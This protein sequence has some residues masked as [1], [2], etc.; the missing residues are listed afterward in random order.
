M[1]RWLLTLLLLSMVGLCSRPA[2]AVPP[3]LAT[4]RAEWTWSPTP[5]HYGVDPADVR[6]S[7]PF[8]PRGTPRV[9]GKVV[10]EPGRAVVVWMSALSTV[11]VRKT[12]PE[13][14][15]TLS[16]SRVEPSAGLATAR[17]DED[18]IAVAP[19][20]WL[21]RH[22]VGW[23][24]PWLVQSDRR[25]EIVVEQ[26]VARRGQRI[27]E[28]VHDNVLQWVQLR[29]SMPHLP[30]TAGSER[31]VRRRL[32][33]REVAREIQ[34]LSGGNAEVR[35][36]L[37]A[38]RMIR[39]ADELD[40]LRPLGQVE[41]IVPKAAPTVELPH[42]RDDP[43]SASA[44]LHFVR[45]EP[46]QPWHFGVRGPGVLRLGLRALLPP[47][48]PRSRPL[49]AV[50]K[51]RGDDGREHVVRRLDVLASV[52]RVRDVGDPQAPIPTLVDAR[53][54]AGELASLEHTLTVP[55]RPG[56][57][58]YWVEIA[59]SPVA[60]RARL[61][62]VVPQAHGR[63]STQWRA[64]TRR[65]ALARLDD[66]RT[67]AAH[68]TRLLLADPW[69][70]PWRLPLPLRKTLGRDAPRVRV[71]MELHSLRRRDIDAVSR[72]ARG[73]QVNA[74]LPLAPEAD[75]LDIELRMQMFE[76][77]M[78]AGRHLRA[79]EMLRSHAGA[80]NG[81]ELP[82]LVD[83]VQEP[84]RAWP[85]M[86]ALDA[87]A[88]RAPL[89]SRLRAAHARLWSW[90][91]W[92][93]LH[94]T[95]DVPAWRW[96]EPPTARSPTADS[97]PGAL[98][99]MPLRTAVK[100]VAPA[101]PFERDR[102]PVL[103]ISVHADAPVKGPLKLQVGDDVFTTPMLGLSEVFEV[104]VPV[105]THLVWLD[106]PEGVHALS[107]LHPAPG[108]T[109]AKGP[110]PLRTTMWP[111]HRDG[112]ATQFD[113]GAL[114][115]DTL[116]QV[117]LR[118]IDPPSSPA[119]PVTAWVCFDDGQRRR[120]VVAPG[121][122]PTELITM[123]GA[124]TVS[125]RVHVVVPASRRATRV[126]VES[127]TPLAVAAK[128]RRWDPPP[129]QAFAETT[130]VATRGP[131]ARLTPQ[132]RHAATNRR[133]VRRGEPYERLRQ[134]TRR[135]AAQ[136]KSIR[137]RVEH[138]HRLLDVGDRQ[139]AQWELLDVLE[140]NPLRPDDPRVPLVQALQA[141]IDAFLTDD[142]IRQPNTP[143]PQPLLLRP[144][145]AALGPDHPSRSQVA[146]ATAA[147]HEGRL[148]EAFEGHADAYAH[149]EALG[150]GYAAALAY[151]DALWGTPGQPLD[152]SWVPLRSLA[153]GVTSRV[154]AQIDTPRLRRLHNELATPGQWQPLQL[155]ERS[156]GTQDRGRRANTRALTDT[157]RLWWAL[158]AP[159]WAEGEGQLLRSGA[160]SI[161]KLELPDP[162]AIE[163]EVFCDDRRSDADELSVELRT[164]D[165][166]T[167]MQD[168]TL[169]LPRRRARRHRLPARR[170]SVRIELRLPPGAPER[171]CA[172]RWQ[173]VRSATEALV[174]ERP[175][176][177]LRAE[178]G[179]PVEMIVL[180]PT[181]LRLNLEPR[182]EDTSTTATVQIADLAG[183]DP[184]F[185]S[186][187]VEAVGDGGS[188]PVTLLIPQAG[189]QRLTINTDDEGVLARVAVRRSSDGSDEAVAEQIA[190]LA[191]TTHGSDT[192][193]VSAALDLDP[194]GPYWPSGAD[195]RPTERIADAPSDATGRLGSFEAE[196]GFSRTDI[197][198]ADDPRPRS[199]LRGS[200]LW[201]RELYPDHIWLKLATH[202]QG[203][204]GAGG[205]GGAAATAYAQLG[206]RRLRGWAS[207]A[208]WA[209]RY[210]DIPASS[211]RA[212]LHL[213]RP[214]GITPSL[215][216]IPYFRSSYRHQS[217]DDAQF[218]IDIDPSHAQVFSA[219]VE[220]H[221][222][223]LTPGARLRWNPYRDLQVSGEVSA[224]PNSV[225]DSLDHVDG[226]VNL[227]GIIDTRLPLLVRYGGAYRASLRF[228]DDDRVQ[229]FVRHS[230]SLN[231]G[232][233]WIFR[234]V[235]RLNLDL[236]DT[237]YLS[238]PFAPRN[239]VHVVLSFELTLDRGVRDT[240]PMEL[241][242]RPAYRYR[243][244]QAPPRRSAR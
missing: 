162:H 189:A 185:V 112:R 38:W 107:N 155:A 116:V 139:R 142:Y 136:P 242:F 220:D 130:T 51:T 61:G 224:T 33:D 68:V 42:L 171:R 28:H 93:R 244:W 46:E 85:L 72:M 114:P 70:A 109:H 17:V 134:S 138:A 215:A 173:L 94:P 92:A 167:P 35:Q 151:A 223:V 124:P 76:L 195:A 182:R 204:D 121:S 22:P 79:V 161:I 186:L 31:Y 149:S 18:G 212:T 235:G 43:T 231:A 191:P 99:S 37:I 41:E 48:G 82:A 209:E 236:R 207:V 74:W 5:V 44:D 147:A 98:W 202:G 29:G 135:I 123:P 52:A 175:L 97:P 200:V 25:V 164:E 179:R 145:M 225:P 158:L 240:S 180:G 160:R 117:G 129:A 187:P 137:A 156:A 192:A 194:P 152:P 237:V 16:F 78:A 165:S 169:V 95:T 88:A 71:F 140:A 174:S 143:Y 34:D 119:E 150:P 176:R 226:A 144:A 59:G 23:G 208:S 91:S 21:L 125:D 11:R 14:R 148:R 26:A 115:R 4:D 219:Y 6:A 111:A 15:G 66:Q 19:G 120:V 238:R 222:L 205:A 178:P 122:R 217:L 73:R 188:D 7:A 104:A 211:V 193:A 101:H 228:E 8:V 86:G 1:A 24:A 153:Y 234:S 239:G 105:G 9:E 55:L 87:V 83:A 47:D 110:S 81:D 199:R 214:L 53:T 133:R 45:V 132:T 221:P 49:S 131:G 84:G 201:R 126:W 20:T 89:A 65:R 172:V 102:T 203:R 54:E 128:V 32:A 27:W 218:D 157:E 64:R 100:L 96:V 58:E 197:A 177:W 159:P 184:Q 106:A 103:R 50:V 141:R 10:I 181:A 118:V 146:E 210:G 40:L 67:V 190:A 62:R 206:S 229:T 3:P 12:R 227:Q 168:D 60:L 2:A 230:P 232:V 57:H 154:R 113:L 213:D 241:L 196:L 30:S 108:Q 36:A 216:V 243:W 166:T 163:L 127:E 63:D 183:K 69:V 56:K 198:E 75:A 80:L 90:T 39:A 77:R 13:S 233:T 170:G